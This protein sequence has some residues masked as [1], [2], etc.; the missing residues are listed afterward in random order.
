M[1]HVQRIQRAYPQIYL[2]CHVRH[3]TRRREHGLSDRDASVLAHLDEL[4]PV[5][6]GGLA[7]HLGVGPS[8]VTEAVDRLEARG[9]VVRERGQDKRRVLLR[10][11]ATG[12]DLMQVSSALDAARVHDLIQAVPARDRAAAVHGIELLAKAARKQMAHAK[13]RRR[14]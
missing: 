10:I 1:D 4:S 14:A 2:A 12:R 6:A 5:P 9:L 13:T 7:R 8:T 3:T 11:T